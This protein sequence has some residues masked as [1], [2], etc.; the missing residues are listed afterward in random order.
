[1]LQR[2]M[3]NVVDMHLTEW[4]TDNILALKAFRCKNE[5]IWQKMRTTINL[6][7]VK[8]TLEK[9]IRT[10]GTKGHLL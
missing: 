9:K 10:D 3:Y 8:K 7:D 6:D 4:M 2:R 1:M 5:L